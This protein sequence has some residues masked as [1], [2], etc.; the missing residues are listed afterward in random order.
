VEDAGSGIEVPY[1]DRLGVVHGVDGQGNVL[2][3]SLIL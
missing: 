1:G 3:Q 2:W